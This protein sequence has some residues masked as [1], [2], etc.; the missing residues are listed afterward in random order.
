MESEL[1][2]Y[3]TDAL[4]RMMD[5]DVDHGE[6]FRYRAE[7]CL[8]RRWRDGVDID[9]LIDL[10]RSENSDDRM[11]GAYYL[12]EA[13]PRSLRFAEAAVALAED[14]IP[15]CRM[16]LVGYITNTGLYGDAI[17]VALAKFMVDRDLA[18][19]TA[20]INWAVYTTDDRFDHFSRLV[21]AGTGV[22]ASE[23][24]SESELKRGL[25]AL[26]IARRLR[27]GETV[28]A[29]RKDTFEEDSFTFDHLQFFE[30]RLQRYIR[31]RK[32]N[33]VT[34]PNG[35]EKYETGI[36]GEQYDNLGKLKS[37]L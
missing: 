5:E 18:V 36:L 34:S 4:L 27:D 24:W 20:A 17:G 13:D 19:R 37:D 31:R 2:Q 23:F 1:S 14:R 6:R 10:I 9:P 30:R 25:R 21:E 26:A 16:M 33:A 22:A 8:F 28:A 35:F 32:D 11:R 3:S 29:I 15:Y 7:R 12:S